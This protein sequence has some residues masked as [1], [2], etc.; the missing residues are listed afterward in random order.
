MTRKQS[1]I[2][3]KSV[4]TMKEW[5]LLYFLQLPISYMAFQIGSMSAPKPAKHPL[6]RR[7]KGREPSTR[8]ENFMNATNMTDV[9]LYVGLYH[10]KTA[11]AS[12]S[13]RVND[14]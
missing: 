13:N 10:S 8:D 14:V 6:L 7:R 3:T 4:I 2:P 1:K 9:G 12:P 5:N 11:I